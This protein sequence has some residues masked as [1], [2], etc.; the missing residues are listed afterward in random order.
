M[1]VMDADLQDPP[2]VVREMMARWREGFD[3]VYGVRRRRTARPWFKRLTAARLLSPAARDARRR[4]DPG[5]RRR[6]S[7]D[8]P[9]GGAG[10]ARAAREA[11]LRARHGG[12]GRVPPDRGPLRA[13]G[14]LRRRD[15]VPVPQDAALRDRRHHLVLHVSAAPRDLARRAGGLVASSAPGLGRLREVLRQRRRSRLDDD[16]DPG[17]VRRVGAAPDDGHPR[18]VRRPHLRRGQAPPALRRRRGDQPA[19]A[20]R[21]QCRRSVDVPLINA[22]SATPS[23]TTTSVRSWW[24]ASIGRRCIATWSRGPTT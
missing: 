6:L 13:P 16:H 10:A 8:E 4:I 14:A 24:A 1:V 11:P 2:E 9:P 22:S 3:V 12:L 19:A 7:P 17:R 23:S 18:R 20:R 15:Q 5:R 21:R